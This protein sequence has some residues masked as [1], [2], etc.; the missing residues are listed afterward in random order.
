MSGEL[1]RSVHDKPR[2]GR[3]RRRKEKGLASILRLPLD[4]GLAGDRPVE[5]SK[6]V[7]M[8]LRPV[9]GHPMQEVMISISLDARG[10]IISAFI[11][12]LGTLTA[13]LA[14]PREIFRDAIKKCAASIILV[15]T[16][17]S[18]DPEPSEE[19]YVLT[20][21]IR[22]AGHVVGIPVL[23]HVILGKDNHWSFGDHGILKARV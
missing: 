12:A 22:D 20:R 2:K 4:L 1:E 19:D 15:H 8:I 18:G 9:L 13:C 14:H 10:R 23:D 16:H 21:R 11:V 3:R 17:P 7:A 6:T 5:D